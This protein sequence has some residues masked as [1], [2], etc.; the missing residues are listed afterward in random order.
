MIR[1]NSG[2]HA[3]QSFFRW[4]RARLRRPLVLLAVAGAAVFAFVA[5]VVF[6]LLQGH[7]PFSPKDLVSVSATIAVVLLAIPYSLYQMDVRKK[8]GSDTAKG[9][10]QGS[11]SS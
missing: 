10:R 8:A 11:R 1:N 3:A 5:A 2:G 6:N 7:D 4:V 9:R